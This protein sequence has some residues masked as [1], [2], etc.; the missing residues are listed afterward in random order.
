MLMKQGWSY[1]AKEKIP[2]TKAVLL[3]QSKRA[4]YQAGV[5]TYSELTMQDR[6]SP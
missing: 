2:P 3:Q 4:A 1:S 5:W 6:P